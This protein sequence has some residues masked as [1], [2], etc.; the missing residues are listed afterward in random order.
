MLARKLAAFCLLV[1]GVTAATAQ[2][3]AN[4]VVLI[5]TNHGS[6]KVELYPEKAPVTVK[7]FLDYVDAKHYD[8]TIFHRVIGKENS[9]KDFMIQ[10]GGMGADMKEKETKGGIRNESSNGLS[11]ARGTIAMARTNNPDSATAQFYINVADN[12]FLDGKGGRPGYAVFGR[13]IEG[14]DIVDRIKAVKTGANDVPVET[15]L[16][17]SISRVKAK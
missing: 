4:P 6:V 5:D 14:M 3:A 17:K 7:N 9:G 2:N 1:L 13:V 10:G 12:T 16:I 11:N 8:G 15:V